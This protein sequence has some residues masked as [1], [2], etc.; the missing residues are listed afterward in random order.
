MKKHCFILVTQTFKN[1]NEG[2]VNG[3]NI[4]NTATTS[5]GRIVISINAVNEFPDLFLDRLHFTP[6][7]LDINDFPTTE[8]LQ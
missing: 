6:V 1:A 3:C 7:W 8:N 4:L 5:D 2:A